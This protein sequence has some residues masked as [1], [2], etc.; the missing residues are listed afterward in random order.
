MRYRRLL[1]FRK[2]T[3]LFDLQNTSLA[4]LATKQQRIYIII[5]NKT[6]HK[7]GDVFICSRVLNTKP[8]TL[9]MIE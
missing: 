5:K 9:I 1:I 4:Q 2:L 3:L 6:I 7:H 8:F